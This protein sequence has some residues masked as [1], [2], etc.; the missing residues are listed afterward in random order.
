VANILEMVIKGDDQ[1]S[2]VLEGIQGKIQGMSKGLKV[3]GVAMTA[4]GAAIIGTM[5]LSIKS[6]AEA[7]D[8]V[9]KMALRTGYSTEALSELRYAAELSGTSI[10][11][12]DKS[13]KRMASTLLDAEMGLTTAVD[14]MDALGVSLDDFKGLGPEE[15]FNKFLEAIAGVE[16]PL[17]RSA[18]AQDIFGKSGTDLLPLLANGA[19]G[20]AAMRAEASELGLVFDQEAADKAAG[21]NDSLTELKGGLEG[22]KMMIAENVIPVLMPLIEKVKDIIGRVKA[23]IDA[24]PELFR[25]I[26]IVVGG[27]GALMMILGP[28]LIILPQLVAGIGMVSGALAFLAANPIVLIIIGIVALIAAI[29]LL[30]KNWDWVKE[31]ALAVWGAIANFFKAIWE[32]IVGFFK[33][34]WDKILLILFPAVGIAVLIAK[35][36]D[37][38][39]DFFKG[40]WANIKQIFF[41][42][43]NWII[44]KI[45]WLIEKIN[46]IPGINIGTIGQVGP[47]ETPTPWAVPEFQRGGI[48]PHT[49]LAFLHK[50]EPVLPA[51]TTISVPIYLD[52]ELITEKIVKRVG[53]MAR[54]QGY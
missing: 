32:K 27:L 51:N 46:L 26:M 43:I 17:R 45:N 25:V 36:W 28:I 35:N 16:D 30:I 48:M 11:G 31:K 37:K 47:Q 6:F 40:M 2:K 14:A 41:D 29:V 24:N 10:Q 50:G 52:G 38:V 22:V 9:Q 49:G 39:V 15:A 18:L 54:L 20:L 34:N 33:N 23:W 3:A 12:I 21:F 4:A 42:S 19:E 13:T 5:A 1:A 8:E 7:G 44:D 53:N